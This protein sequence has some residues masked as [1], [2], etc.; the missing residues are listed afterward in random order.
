MKKCNTCNEEKELNDFGVN[1]IYKRKKY[2]HSRCKQCTKNI[3]EDYMKEYRN[4]NKEYFLQYNKQWIDNNKERWKEYSNNWQK[5]NNRKKYN[6]D[7]I[8]KLRM[9]IGARIRLALKSQGKNKLGKTINYLGCDYNKLKEHL[10]NH[11]IKGMC[12]ENY[13]QWE[14]DHIIPVSKGGS[15]NYLNLQPLWKT[16]NRKKGNKIL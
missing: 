11:F 16:D 8:Y 1:R 14:I 6:N 5:E 4:E 2:L 7:P 15:F 9:C 3:Y 12:W 13:G 10:E